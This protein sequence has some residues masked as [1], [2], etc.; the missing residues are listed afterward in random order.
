MT[1]QKAPLATG[2]QEKMMK[3]LIQNA[4]NRAEEH[5]NRQVQ[6]D[7]TDFSGN[8]A[9]I[10]VVGC[11]GAGGNSADRMM[12]IGIEGADIIAIN[13]DA[14][15]L[16]KIKANKK[17]LIGKETTAG[18]GAG[19]DPT[20][21]EAAARESESEIKQAIGGADL[22]FVT[23]GLGGGTGT[24]SAPVVAEIA[25]KMGALAIGVATLPFE[26]EGKHRWDNASSGLSKLEAA[27]DTLI[28]VPNDKLLQIVPDIPIATAFKVADEILV[29][30]VKGIAELITKP[31]LINLD[32]ADV[33]AVM[34]GGGIALIGLGESDSDNRASEA[35]QRAVNNP[36]LDV[37]IT[38]AKG[39]LVDVIGGP[40]LTLEESR[41]I[42]S[43]VSDKLEVGA[44]VIWGARIEETMKESVKVLLI[45]TGIQSS[46]V[47]AREKIFEQKRKEKM[48][49][50]L[51]ISFVETGESS[52]SQSK[53]GKQFGSEGKVKRLF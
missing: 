32:F 24:G 3:G 6:S 48:E 33:R 45:V 26:M 37:D 15:D 36:L 35:I 20:V 22:V 9:V 44:K 52:A 30:A 31:G 2:E 27:V 5:K 34:R 38:G 14:Q 7:S 11:G 28:V 19:A 39:A 50:S 51:G 43:V 13:T 4:M 8:R 10:K 23:C 12:E 40:D 53:G 16:M 18:L 1:R 42:V 21:G 49:K 47:M 41:Q 29:N 25:K 17:I 46:Q